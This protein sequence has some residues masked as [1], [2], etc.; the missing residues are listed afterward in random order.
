MENIEKIL[1]K[2]NIDVIKIFK[3]KDVTMFGGMSE[4]Q[5]KHFVLNRKEFPT[6]FSQFNQ[7]KFEMGSRLMTLID[8]G[9]KYKKNNIKI[10]LLQERIKS[11]FPTK[12][13]ETELLN[14]L[15]EI[16]IER[17]RLS[18]ESLVHQANKSALE[19]K[20]FYAIYKKFEKFNDI[21]DEEA[22]KL[23]KEDW[24][25]KSGYY[26]ELQQRYGLTPEGF[27]LLPH[28]QGGLQKLIESLKQDSLTYK[29]EEDI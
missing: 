17:L 2:E 14:K 21:S 20:S 10:E 11:T 9:L 1:D 3:D 6:D 13:K 28:E 29:K 5:I 23:E 27:H 18:N 8:L 25:I 22:K 26:V 4:F 19:I 16:D 7:S 12:S 15:K 24:L